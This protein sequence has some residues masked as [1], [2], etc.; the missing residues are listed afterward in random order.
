MTKHKL[1]R[2]KVF[3][4]GMPKTGTTSL[5]FCFK[6]L[7]YKH[8]SYNMKL[9]AEVCRGERTNALKVAEKYE[10]FEDWPW[11]LIFKELDRKFPNS[12]FVL[13]VRKDTQAYISSLEKH[14]QREGRFTPHY[15]KPA[16]YDDIWPDEGDGPN[17]NEFMEKYEKHNQ[18]VINYFKDRPEDLKVL[19]WETGDGWEELCSFLNMEAP[20]IK[21]P[22]KNA[23][24]NFK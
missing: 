19:C 8:H 17:Y 14:H 3:G 22:H 15:K 10:S 4:I 1:K 9:A 2:T 5:G 13:T 12:K 18:E 20:N 16:W 21:F 23:A 11:F 24:K 6:Q 7:G